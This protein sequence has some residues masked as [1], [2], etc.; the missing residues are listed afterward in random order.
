MRNQIQTSCSDSPVFIQSPASVQ[1]I[2]LLYIA[3]SSAPPSF[4]HSNLESICLTLICILFI[5]TCFSLTSIINIVSLPDD[6]PR[7]DVTEQSYNRSRSA[8][9]GLDGLL[10]PSA[11]MHML[12]Q[13]QVADVPERKIRMQSRARAGLKAR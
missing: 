7:S 13:L 1:S 6:I 11:Y 10:D 3:L 9:R 2:Y 4:A 12:N 8:F 5:H